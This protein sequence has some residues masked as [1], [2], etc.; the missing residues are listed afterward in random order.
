LARAC[1]Q[2]RDPAWQFL[3]SASDCRLIDHGFEECVNGSLKMQPF[4]AAPLQGEMNVGLLQS[5]RN[6]RPWELR[7]H[8]D[9]VVRECVGGRERGRWQALAD[10]TLAPVYKPFR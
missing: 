7:P 8:G 1:A 5:K 10:N 6:P 9:G 3:N 4:Y 2:Y